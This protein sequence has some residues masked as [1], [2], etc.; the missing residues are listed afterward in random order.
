MK[1]LIVFFGLCIA[2]LSHA[3]G[4][5]DLVTLE[6]TPYAGS[7]LP[8]K[9]FS[10][11]IIQKAFQ[12]RNINARIH[13]LPWKEAVKK[14]EKGNYHGVFS[15]YASEDRARRFLFTRPYAESMLLFFSLKGKQISYDSLGDL[16]D[17]RIGITKG[18]ANTPEFDAADDLNKI[19]FDTEADALESLLREKVDLV[20][21]DKFVCFHLM[22]TRFKNYKKEITSLTPALDKRLLY[23]MFSKKQ[24][25]AEAYVAHFNEGLAEIK[26]NGL[27]DLILQRHRFL[28]LKVI[29]L[30]SLEWPPYAGSRIHENG[31][32]SQ[33]VT[34]AYNLSGYKVFIR[35]RPWA[36]ALKETE[37][38][39]YDLAFPA[40]YSDARNERFV[41]V[42][43]DISSRI[44][45]MKI[46][47]GI[48]DTYG[49]L[50]DLH[51]WRIGIV[52]GYVYRPD[53]DR[54]DSLKKYKGYSDM[55]LVRHLIRGEIDLA[56]I[57]KRVAGHLIGTLA[58][59]K[60][61][62]FLSPPLDVK[63]LYLAFSKRGVDL[64][65]K[66]QA[67][68]YGYDELRRSG[69]LKGLTGFIEE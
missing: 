59:D 33:I 66:I 9:G 42:P 31:F 5:L 18:F 55:E 17:Y 54:A 46:K 2:T 67:F 45:F 51:P 58:G 37:S 61:F 47:S 32:V 7:H 36:R 39:I 69:K 21:M 19:A 68:K 41:L 49:A 60:A 44:G 11:E 8:N 62:K 13:F 43:L 35:F 52:H 12:A 38:G 22:S 30:V 50:S 16:R 57:D 14:T 28:P 63:Q 3:G 56:A 65:R 53:F 10:S 25:G 27:Y 4:P 64:E 23:L 26:K 6:W 24:P 29:E 15:A 20:L 40:Y 34:K 1:S 48:P